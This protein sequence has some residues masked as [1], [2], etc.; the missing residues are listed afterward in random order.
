MRVPII[1]IG[2]SR[3]IRIPQ[4]LLRQAGFGAEVELDIGDGRITLKRTAAPDLVP[5]FASLPELDDPGIQR[6][7][8]KLTGVDLMTAL[9]GA[10]AA[11]KDAVYRNLSP[12]VRAYLE[13][14]VARLESGD[15]KDLLIERSRNLIAEAMLEA[16]R[17]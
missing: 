8:R 9:V 13:P 15:A 6:V 4:A 14:T 1:D 12:R 7:L 2:N 3:G 5:E 11:V 10:E 16:S 17:E